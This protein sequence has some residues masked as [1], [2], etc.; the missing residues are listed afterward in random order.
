[1]VVRIWS[2]KMQLEKGDSLTKGYASVLWDCTR[3]SMTQNNLQD[4]FTFG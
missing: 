4:C 2:E 3:I 1:M